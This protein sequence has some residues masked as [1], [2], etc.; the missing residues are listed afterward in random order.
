[1]KIILS[2]SQLKLVIKESINVNRLNYLLDKVSDSGIESLSQEEREDLDDMSNGRN[3]RKRKHV[4]PEERPHSNSSQSDS[5]SFEHLGNILNPNNDG[6]EGGD[7]MEAPLH[8]FMD[9]VPK[10]YAIMVG[11]YKWKIEPIQDAT[12]PHIRLTDGEKEFHVTPFVN[13]RNRI[14]IDYLNGNTEIFDAQEVSPDKMKDYVKL[15]YKEAI[16]VFIR[17]ALKQL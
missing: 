13:N 6:E 10:T 9:F 3:I 17:K 7:E 1:M 5:G 14:L 8:H 4:E 15:F 11:D 12:G 2:E 16:P